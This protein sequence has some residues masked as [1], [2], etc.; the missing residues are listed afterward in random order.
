MRQVVNEEVLTPAARRLGE[1][2]AAGAV[3]RP[4]AMDDV[5]LSEGELGYADVRLDGWRYFALHE[6]VYERRT[7][8]VGGPYLMAAGALASAIGNRRRRQAAERASEPQW[9]P[10]GGLRV[11]VTAERLLICH[12]E[13]W[14]SV[15]LSTITR[16][17]CDVRA[18]VMDLFFDAD[19][20]YRLMGPH[21]ELLEVFLRW[22]MRRN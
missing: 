21:V 4:R 15:W 16:V 9:R 17:D 19:P 12:D 18:G 1:A 5:P 14:W 6:P 3:L 22:R 10:L 7:V 13:A 11:I 20:P 2:L 8:L